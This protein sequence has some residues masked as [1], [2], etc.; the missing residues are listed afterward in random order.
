MRRAGLAT[1]LNSHPPRPKEGHPSEEG[2]KQM[3]PEALTLPGGGPH[4]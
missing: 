4:G 2:M 1:R 3:L